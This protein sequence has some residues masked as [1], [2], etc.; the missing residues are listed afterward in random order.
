MQRLYLR[1]TPAS[2]KSIPNLKSS[3]W[4]QSKFSCFQTDLWSIFSHMINVTL[5]GMLGLEDASYTSS[6]DNKWLIP[7]VV[8]VSVIKVKVCKFQIWNL[9][10]Q[11]TNFNKY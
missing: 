7:T 1:E 9:F 10:L 2:G 5:L 8:L 6:I 3:F 11:A 4:K